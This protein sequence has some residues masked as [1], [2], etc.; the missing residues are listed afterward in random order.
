MT[1]TFN[2][3]TTFTLSIINAGGANV[4]T[5]NI[6]VGLAMFYGGLCQL[7]A[8][9]WEFATGNTFAATALSSYG[10]FWLSY[11]AIFIP[12]FG[13]EAA[14][15][16]NENE[17]NKALGIYL[18]NWFIITFLFC[19]ASSRSSVA[20]FFIFFFLMIT[21][22]LLAAHSFTGSTG[23]QTAAGVMGAI[24]SFNAWYVALAGLLTPDSSWFTLPTI[25]LDF[26]S[27]K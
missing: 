16:S 1:N 12:W 6:V 18:I 20:L 15:A 11:G 7:L 23:V 17:M 3:G 14:Y 24:T 19:I 9:M 21:F 26:K 22:I 25:S 10:G 13:I 27:K 5:P 2:I 4:S 8:G